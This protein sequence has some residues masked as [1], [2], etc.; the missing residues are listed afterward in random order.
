MMPGGFVGVDVVFVISRFVV[1]ASSVSFSGRGFW[2]FVS[3]FY[4]RR[5]KRIFPA[6]IVCLLLTAYALARFEQEET[7]QTRTILTG[8]GGRCSAPGDRSAYWCKG[9]SSLGRLRLAVLVA[10]WRTEGR[11]ALP[12]GHQRGNQGCGTACL[13]R[14]NADDNGERVVAGARD[15]FPFLGGRMISTRLLG[16]AVLIRALLPQDR[17]VEIEH[18]TPDE[19]VNVARFLARVVGRGHARQMDRT[20]RIHWVNELQRNRLTSLRSVFLALE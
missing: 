20:D 7:R 8:F 2:Q 19:T 1:S 4:A 12:D 9:C 16:K 3:Y 13:G 18:L 14:Q 11:T 15:L 6:L 10:I 5:I 17:K